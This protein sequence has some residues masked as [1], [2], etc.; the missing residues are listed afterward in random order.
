VFEKR[1]LQENAQKDFMVIKQ[2]LY[3][4]AK[5][6]I[7]PFALILIFLQALRVRGST[8][9]RQYHGEKPRLIYGPTPI[10]SIKYISQAMRQKGYEARTFVYEVYSIHTSEDYDYHLSDLFRIFFIT[11]RLKKVLIAL[12]GPYRAFLWVLPRFDIFH[13]FF[14]GGFLARTPIRFLEVQLLHLAGKKVV[15]MPYGS[16]VAVPTLIRS[17]EFRQALMM[18]YPYLGSRE[19]LTLNWIRYFTRRADSIV[20]CL[21]HSETLPTWNLLTTHYYPIDTEAWL[22]NGYDSGHNGK[23]GLVTIVHASNHR[24]LKGTEFLISACRELEAEGYRIELRLLE[25]VSNTEVQR[26][27]KESDIIAEQFIHGYALT[28]MEGMSLAK[29]VLS[30]LSDD[31]YYQVHRLYTGLNECPVVSTSINQI[32]DHLRMLIT[33]PEIRRQI[34]EAGRRYVV[35][36]HSYETVARMWE[37]IYRKIWF[38]EE[39][40]LTVWHPDRFLD[41]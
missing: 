14:D 18:K 30:N 39:I 10:I 29:P 38:A 9:N 24:E 22:P 35:K 25:Q 41:G 33:N 4:L 8:L 23:D 26:I 34:G 28:A 2:V 13:Y 7:A 27:M 21:F 5:N 31:H 12:L 32:K 1:F 11:G 15:V 20:V 6:L 17:L 19:K 40:D 16:D 37:L 36:Y 3:N